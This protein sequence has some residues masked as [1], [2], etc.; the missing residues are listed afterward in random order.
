MYHHHMWS[1][2]LW[3]WGTRSGSPPDA[4]GALVT[5]LVD[6]LRPPLAGLTDPLGFYLALQGIHAVL[7]QKTTI[8]WKCLYLLVSLKDSPIIGPGWGGVYATNGSSG[9]A[10][11]I[12]E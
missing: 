10:N 5:R 12:D 6:K 9:E 8:L 11:P 2:H 7:E 1:H 3:C 4:L